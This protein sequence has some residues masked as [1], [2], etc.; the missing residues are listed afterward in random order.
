LERN[1]FTQEHV[2]FILAMWEYRQRKLSPRE[3]Y[4]RAIKERSLGQLTLG[5]VE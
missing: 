2:D 3:A 5:I 4:E 1:L